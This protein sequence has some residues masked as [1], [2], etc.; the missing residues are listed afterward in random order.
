MAPTRSNS[1]STRIKTQLQDARARFPWKPLVAFTLLTLFLLLTLPTKS[2]AAGRKPPQSAPGVSTPQPLRKVALG[3]VGTQAFRLPNG[4][5][6][7]LSADLNVMF[8]TA[9]TQTGLL[10]PVAVHGQVDLCEETLK[11]EAAVST[12][13]M[14]VGSGRIRVGYSPSGTETPSFGLEGSVGVKVGVIAMDFKLMK[15]DARDCTSI[16]ASTAQQPFPAFSLEFNVN[17]SDL[18]L[19]PELIYNTPMG[20]V[21]RGIM[22]EGM[23]K[24]VAQT[25]ALERLGWRARVRDYDPQTGILIFDQGWESLIGENQSFTIYESA[26]DAIGIGC[27]VYR[28]AAYAETTTVDPISSLAVVTETRSP[29][30]VKRG[31]LVTIRRA[32]ASAGAQKK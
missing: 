24:I 29:R 21:L 23:R 20:N 22:Q 16:A 17:I 31:D 7:D 18:K 15:C 11:L 13:Q 4:Q 3:P 14:E 8:H 26:E 9:V 6:M 28:V 30:G 2:R 12:L 19:G 27:D 25:S 32:P 5:Q 1:L 10:A